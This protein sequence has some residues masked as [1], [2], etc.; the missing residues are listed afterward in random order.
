MLTEAGTSLRF[1]VL[2]QPPIDD[3]GFLRCV[4]S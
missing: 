2:V 1:F 4:E 3:G